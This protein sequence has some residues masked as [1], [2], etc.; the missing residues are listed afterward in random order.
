MAADARVTGA[1]D[2]RKLAG[3][4]AK[5]DLVPEFDRELRRVGGPIVTDV[6]SQIARIPSSGRKH[7]GL[8]AAMIRATGQLV[9]VSKQAVRLR[10]QTNPGAMPPNQRAMPAALESQAFIHPVYGH[11]WRVVQRGHPYLRPTVL[12]HLPQARSAVVRA[13]DSMATKLT[14]R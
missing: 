9:T 10:I 6:R 4:L 13:A 5:A 7:T 2:L 12:R 14:R 1:D 3:R 8:R 11:Q